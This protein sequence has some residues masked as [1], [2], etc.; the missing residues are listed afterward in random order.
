MSRRKR[1]SIK[2]FR[3]G[4]VSVY[5]HHGSWW[6]YYRQCG[7]PIRHKIAQTRNEAEQVAA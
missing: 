4:R 7:K 1:G 2:R 3:V 6:A 5:L